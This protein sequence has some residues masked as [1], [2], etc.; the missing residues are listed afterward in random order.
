MFT[1]RVE[2]LSDVHDEPPRTVTVEAFGHT[3]DLNYPLTIT[4]P[5]EPVRTRLDAVLAENVYWDWAPFDYTRVTT[6]PGLLAL[7]AT[8]E[9]ARSLMNTAAL[10]AAWSVDTTGRGAPRVTPWP[11]ARATPVAHVTDCAD[12]NPVAAPTIAQTWISD[13]AE[14]LNVTKLENTAAVTVTASDPDSAF[15]HGV[16]SNAIGMPAPTLSTLDATAMQPIADA[17][18]DTYADGIDRCSGVTIP[19]DQ[20][21]PGFVFDMLAALERGRTVTVDRYGTAPVRVQAVIA[22]TVHRLERGSW[23]ATLT[24]TDTALDITTAV[25]D[26]P[27]PGWDTATWSP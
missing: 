1:G 13:M 14:L 17:I 5:A 11:L 26:A 9:P 24:L 15:R 10:S 23:T 12:D 8:D 3:M 7:P 4:R 16:R 2:T 22:G 18:V 21:T 19:G 27:A 25:W 20:Y 6:N